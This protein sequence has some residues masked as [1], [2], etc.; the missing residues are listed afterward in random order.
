MLDKPM[1]RPKTHGG[2]SKLPSM[3]V[4][5]AMLTLMMS[6]TLVRLQELIFM[7]VVKMNQNYLRYVDYSA[8]LLVCPKTLVRPSFSPSSNNVRLWIWS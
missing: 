1:P 2:V 6:L 5:Q 3:A 4:A 8:G 7:P